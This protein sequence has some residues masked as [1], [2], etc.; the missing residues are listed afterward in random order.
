[1]LLGQAMDLNCLTWLIAIVVADQLQLHVMVSLVRLFSSLKAA[2]QNLPLFEVDSKVAGGKRRPQRYPWKG[3]GTENS[4]EGHLVEPSECY[5]TLEEHVESLFFA[6][7][8]R[9]MNETNL[10]LSMT[11]TKG[12]NFV[13]N[14]VA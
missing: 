3:W 10:V 11:S 7:D 14:G 2:V 4:H 13:S 5:E 9:S 6:M 1:M 12:E 8:E